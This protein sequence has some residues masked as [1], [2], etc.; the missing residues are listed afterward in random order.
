[1]LRKR[2]ILRRVAAEKF[3]PTRVLIGAQVP[4]ARIG[5]HGFCS[6]RIFVGEHQCRD[7]RLASGF[8]FFGDASTD[9]LIKCSEHARLLSVASFDQRVAL[10]AK[11]FA[12]YLRFDS[13]ARLICLHQMLAAALSRGCRFEQGHFCGHV[14][15]NRQRACFGCGEDRVPMRSRHFGEH[16]DEIRARSGGRIDLPC[17]IL[18]RRSVDGDSGGKN[19]WRHKFAGIEGFP[20]LR[21]QRH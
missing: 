14:T 4:P 9:I 21:H 15:C 16:F 3:L 8:D 13:R 6:Q 12:E 5:R 11:T 18:R 2:G 19:S 10:Q 7:L 20:P 17:R 1:L